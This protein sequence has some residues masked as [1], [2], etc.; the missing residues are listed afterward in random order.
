MTCATRHGVA[1][2][3]EPVKERRGSGMNVQYY[4]EQIV[5]YLSID[6]GPISLPCRSVGI[7]CASRPVVTRVSSNAFDFSASVA[8]S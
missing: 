6:Q 3:R 7:S 5:C 8:I 1:T 4:E 2:R